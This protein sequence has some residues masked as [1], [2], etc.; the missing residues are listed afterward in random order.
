MTEIIKKI[1]RVFTGV[2]VSTSMDKTITANIDRNVW[3][4][5]YNKQITKSRKY[6]VH[7]E[8]GIA[9]VGNIIMFKECKPISKDKRWTLV[10]IVK[11]RK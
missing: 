11:D 8:K 2:V 5:T 10:K 4:K 3:H 7:D 1:D 9:T 6:K